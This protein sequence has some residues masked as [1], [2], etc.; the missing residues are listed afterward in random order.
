MPR[1][2]RTLDRYNRAF[3]ERCW[4]AGT[5]V[6]IPGVRAAVERKPVV[7]IGAGLRPRLP[8]GHAVF[9]DLSRAACVKLRRAGAQTVR[10]SVVELP[11]RPEALGGIHAY[12]VLEHVSDDAAAVAELAR[13]LVPGGRLVLSTP[14]HADRWHGFDR[15]VGHARRYDPGALVALMR[16]HGFVLEAF[17]P[18][19]LRPRSRL[20]TR[21]GAYFMTRW[22][23]LAFRYEERFLRRK[24][25]TR[26]V[27]IVR[28]IDVPTFV[29]EAAAL[30]GAVT[31]W[32]RS[33]MRNQNVSDPVTRPS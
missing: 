31:V 8:V 6:P 33:A 16:A 25:P 10:A 2:A 22:P 21:L 4:R 9:V 3:Y 29:R 19:G 24:D 27:V 28:R 17:A 15:I 14:L 13:V 23:H 20:L 1:A 30:D 18:F 11:F 26:D 32:T 12:E 7:E 5:V